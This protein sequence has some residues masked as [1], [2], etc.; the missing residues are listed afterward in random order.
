MQ[1][2]AGGYNKFVSYVDPSGYVRR[3][4]Y[5]GSNILSCGPTYA[6]LEY[7]YRADS[8]EYEY[9]LRH[10]EFPQ[11]DENRT[12]YTPEVEFLKDLT[13]KDAWKN[14]ALHCYDTKNMSFRY[15]SYLDADGT[16]QVTDLPLNTVFSKKVVLNRGGAYFS[17][18]GQVDGRQG[19]GD[20]QF[21]LLT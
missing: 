6:D 2:T 5:T 12:Y 14:F 9:T 15:F 11:T 10:M 18:S 16:K 13:V 1:F 3:A 8:G 20:G 21:R 17:I 7:S 19:C 4:E